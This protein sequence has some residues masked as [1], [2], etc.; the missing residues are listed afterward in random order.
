MEEDLL[1]HQIQHQIQLSLQLQV[2]HLMHVV[3]LNGLETIIVMM[4]ITMK[5][6]A[7]M[8]ETV[9]EMR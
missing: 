5:N 6:V 1:Q 8:E 7:G 3:L 9:V 4:T 2:P